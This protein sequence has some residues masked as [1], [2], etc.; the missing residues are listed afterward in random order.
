MEIWK[1]CVDLPFYQVSNLGNVRSL[2]R[3]IFTKNGV[4]KN[5]KGRNLSLANLNG[6][7]YFRTSTPDFTH[8][9]H[10]VVLKAFVGIPEVG[11]QACHENGNR[12][13]NRLENLRWDTPVN[14]NR[15]KYK[16]GTAL[17]G[18]KHPMSKISDKQAMEIKESNLSV[19]ELMKIYG[20]SRSHTQSIKAGKYRSKKF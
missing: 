19:K 12:K 5:I 18:Q 13:D 14:N 3:T 10:R 7:L 17:I 15:D 4:Q 6:Y 20:L 1:N 2:D 9:V 11:M 16:H 8:L